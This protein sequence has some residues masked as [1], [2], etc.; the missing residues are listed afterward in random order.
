MLKLRCN[1][2]WG[3]KVPL[4]GK[5]KLKLEMIQCLCSEP[6]DSFNYR[7]IHLS[8][9][10]KSNMCL[11]QYEHFDRQECIPVGCIP[12]AAVAVWEGLHQAPPGPGIPQD[13][14]PLD[15]APPRTR[16]PPPVDRMTDRCKHITLPQTSFAVTSVFSG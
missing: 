12:P 1:M 11:K 5:K 4:L 16:H 7:P 6:P 8:Y 15:Q 2:L 10:K 9:T 14:V 13:Q 3:W